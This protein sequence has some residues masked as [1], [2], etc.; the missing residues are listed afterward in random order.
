M[1]QTF[2]ILPVRAPVPDEY[3]DEPWVYRFLEA[4]DSE[5]YRC[6]EWLE[7]R[8]EDWAEQKELQLEEYLDER[9]FWM[10]AY[11]EKPIRGWR[12]AERESFEQASA[13][14][15]E[16]LRWEYIREWFSEDDD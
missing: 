3:H 6:F 15:W 10:T 12:K 2:D 4:G 7:E 14:E 11:G 9:R 13:E 1:R 5:T 16:S 8:H